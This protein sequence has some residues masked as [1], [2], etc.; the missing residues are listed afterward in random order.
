MET[1]VQKYKG[2]AIL[3]DFWATWCGPCIGAMKEM[4][5]LKGELSTKDI[6]FVYIT[7]SS[8]PKKLW[9]ERAKGIDGEHY[10]LTSEKWE[11]I[12]KQM[13]MEGIP[14]YLIYDKEGNLTKKF[15]GYPGNKNMKAE[16]EEALK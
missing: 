9:D 13:D 3:V 5:S 15:T 16:L 2:K 1:I 8:S 12:S 10:Y 7:N 14:T 4:L 11:S 6:V